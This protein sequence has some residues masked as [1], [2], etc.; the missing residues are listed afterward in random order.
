MFVSLGLS[1]LDVYHASQFFSK[2]SFI[3]RLFLKNCRST[4]AW[5]L[6]IESSTCFSHF[7]ILFTF[8][9]FCI[10]TFGGVRT[11]STS[12]PLPCQRRRQAPLT[13]GQTGDDYNLMLHC[14]PVTTGQSCCLPRPAT[15]ELRKTFIAS[16]H[17][18]LHVDT[19]SAASQKTAKKIMKQ[20]AKYESKYAVDARKYV[21]Y[22]K[23]HTLYAIKYTK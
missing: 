9:V 5:L 19:Y 1:F 2:W 13:Q 8:D 11:T 15:C 6:D 20:Y 4:L 22:A 23:Q 18:K 7:I 3:L 10:F 16:F 21:K 17:N 12:A 14:T